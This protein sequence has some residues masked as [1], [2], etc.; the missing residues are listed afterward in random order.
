MKE[1]NAVIHRSYYAGSDRDKILKIHYLDNEILIKKNC[2]CDESYFS[3]P[4]GKP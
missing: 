2:F 1:M 4:Y 3:L